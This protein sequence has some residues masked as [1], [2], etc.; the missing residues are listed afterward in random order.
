MA[1]MVI[2][3]VGT[4]VA[5]VAA[6]GATTSPGVSPTLVQGEA[7][8]GHFDRAL[9]DSLP[10]HFTC[11]AARPSDPPLVTLVTPAPNGPF[12]SGQYVN[13]IVAANMVLQPGK[14]VYLRECA[15]PGGIPPTSLHECDS[16]T[17][18]DGDVTVGAHGTVGYD[19]YPIYSL[20]DR[21][22]LGESSRH[23][24]ICDLTHACILLVGQGHHRLD[25]PHVWSLPFYV[26]P[27]AGDS[28]V[29]PGNGLPEAPYVLALPILAVGIFGGTI[30][31]R[32]RRSRLT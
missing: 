1:A 15:A 4:V 9:A 20:P 22:I 2:V 21:I 29:D 3:A 31:L 18:Q 12:S 13:V 16:R 7:W 6:T 8:C 30:A 19:G 17:I 25:K 14:R 24:P 26:H 5:P 27:T 11:T 10:A 32:R 23:K 28:G